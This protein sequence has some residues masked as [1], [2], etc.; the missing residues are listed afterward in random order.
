MRIALFV[1][2]GV[3]RSGTDRV[4]PALLALIERLARRHQVVIV[5]LTPAPAPARYDLL[6]ATVYDVGGGAG[7]RRRALSVVATE[8]RRAPFDVM[9][10]FWARGPG[11]LAAIAGWRHRVPVILHLAGG[12]MAA[13]RDIAY[14]QR[15]SMRGRWA[16]RLATA[17]ATRVTVASAAMA[18]AARTLGIATDRVPLGPALDQWPAVPPRARDRVRPARLLHMADLNRVK[19]QSTLLRALARVRQHGIPFQLDVAGCDTLGGAVQAEAR[20]LGLADVVT[21]HGRLRYHAL[22]TLA[23]CADLHVMA[24]RHEAGPLAVVEAALAGVPTVGTCVGHLADWA[25]GAAMA[26]PIGDADALAVAVTALLT[27]DNARLRVAQRAQARAAVEH[28]DYTAAQF[29]ALY[30][31]L[32][33]GGA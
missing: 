31:E 6:G 20:A 23:T 14:G 25:P 2:G 15:L 7:H 18:D 9:H 13:I 32:V 33:S 10:A 5:A 24:S 17:G 28:A 21:F 30:G 29:E 3:D 19:D 22:H 1:P 27:D 11:S 26:V 16:L 4:I 12:E 8:H